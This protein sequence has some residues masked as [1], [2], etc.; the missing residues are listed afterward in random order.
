MLFTRFNFEIQNL[1][2][3]YMKLKGVCVLLIAKEYLFV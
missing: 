2:N 1:T 3:A